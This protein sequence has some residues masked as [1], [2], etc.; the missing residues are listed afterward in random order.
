MI[1]RAAHPPG[2]PVTPAG[3]GGGFY[4]SVS[5]TLPYPPSVNTYWRRNGP[6]YFISKA[7]KAFRQAVSEECNSVRGLQCMEGRLS[8]TVGLNPPDRRVRDVDSVC[9]ALL[10]SMQGKVY[11]N[12]S[13]I[14]RLLIVRGGVRPPGVCTVLIEEIA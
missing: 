4:R 6:R 8:M 9:K 1:Q 13:Q 2:A 5:L 10:D 12:D 11:V 3:N 7:G 14:D